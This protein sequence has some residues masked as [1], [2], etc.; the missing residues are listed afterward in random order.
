MSVLSAREPKTTTAWLVGWVLVST[1]GI[2]VGFVGTL[3]LLWSV[4]ETALRA[5][6][7]LVVQ[8]LGG[9]FFGFGVGLATGLAQWVL[10][11][12][13][14]KP[15]LRWVTG[16]VVGGLAGGAVAML[17]SAT[18]ND[19]GGN[20]AVTALAFALLGAAVA[21]GQLALDRTTVKNPLWIVAGA[22]GLGIGALFPLGAL[23][24]E[25]LS[26]VVG[27]LIYGVVTAGAWWWLGQPGDARTTLDAR[28]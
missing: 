28:A 16:S 24:L 26:P 7:Q 5:L 14:G 19:G 2:T 4:S 25:V 6:P 20:L 12:A 21:A 27:G 3:P 11:R 8:M 17:L 1:I 22:A 10:L 15:T 18:L 9:G 13:R 23:N